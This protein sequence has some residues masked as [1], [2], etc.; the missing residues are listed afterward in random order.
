MS[1]SN[2]VARL[3]ELEGVL[4]DYSAEEIRIVVRQVTSRK[5]RKTVRGSAGDME[6]LDFCQRCSSFDRT[7]SKG[8]RPGLRGSLSSLYVHCDEFSTEAEKEDQVDNRA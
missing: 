5:S 1:E 2:D 4:E 7:C 8:R 6:V 3:E